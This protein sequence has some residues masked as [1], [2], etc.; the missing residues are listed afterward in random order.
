M[1]TVGMH[2]G[3]ISATYKDV[4]VTAFYWTPYGYTIFEVSDMDTS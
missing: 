3:Q 2:V 4:D 1:L